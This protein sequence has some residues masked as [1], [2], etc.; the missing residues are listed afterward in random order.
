MSL[1]FLRRTCFWSALAYNLKTAT[2]LTSECSFNYYHNV[3]MARKLVYEGG[4]ALEL[5]PTPPRIIPF[6][7]GNPYK[8]SFA[9]VTGWGVDLR[10]A[11]FCLLVVSWI[12]PPSKLLRAQDLQL[13]DGTNKWQENVEPLFAHLNHVPSR[14]LT[15]CLPA[16]TFEDGFP[17][18][19]VGYVIVPWRVVTLCLRRLFQALARAQVRMPSFAGGLSCGVVDDSHGFLRRDPRL[20]SKW[21]LRIT[22]SLLYDEHMR[23][24]VRVEHRPSFTNLDFFVILPM[25]ILIF[26]ND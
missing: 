7:V 9:T 20:M 19:Q 22:I 23:N 13:H 1:L 8:P 5:P 14:E 10:Y 12:G 11:L 24:R 21:A 15:Y 6:L 3:R 25:I 26:F 17:F 18:P 4:Y 2:V 16:G